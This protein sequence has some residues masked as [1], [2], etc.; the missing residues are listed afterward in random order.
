M[1]QGNETIREQSEAE[2]SPTVQKNQVKSESKSDF[3]P[4]DEDTGGV[5]NLLNNN[6]FSNIDEGYYYRNSIKIM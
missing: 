6:S 3:S 4:V 1:N 5:E 2:E